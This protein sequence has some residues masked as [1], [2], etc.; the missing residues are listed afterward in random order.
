MCAAFPGP[1]PANATDARAPGLEDLRERRDELNRVILQEEEERARIQKEISLMTDRL[2]KL[3]ESLIR[4]QEAR[5]EYDKT[6][7]DSEHAYLQIR[8]SSEKL[9]G[10]LK[11]ERDTLGAR[12]VV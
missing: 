7:T 1:A 9:L 5:R 8:D 4:K 3:N 11:K 2:T 10:V 6:I 12:R